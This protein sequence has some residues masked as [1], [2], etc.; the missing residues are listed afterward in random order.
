[1]FRTDLWKEFM[2]KTAVIL[3]ICTIFCGLN[4]EAKKKVQSSKQVVATKKATKTV[5]RGKD[6][7]RNSFIS[8]AQAVLIDYDTGEILYSH[9]SDEICT[10]SSMTKLMTTYILFEAI[11]SRRIS[12][13]DEWEVSEQAQSMEGSRSFFKAGTKAQAPGR[14]ITLY[15]LLLINFTVL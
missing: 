4:V 15:P 12:L 5:N 14:A 10:P 2:K 8:A 11:K 6:S 1:M 7:S 13:D 3:S 9:N